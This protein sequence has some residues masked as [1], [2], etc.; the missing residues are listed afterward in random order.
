MF[1]DTLYLKIP[2]RN[3]MNKTILQYP[4]QGNNDVYDG[5]GHNIKPQ[6]LSRTIIPGILPNI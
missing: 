2:R 6:R 3:N 5:R 4:Y 1:Y